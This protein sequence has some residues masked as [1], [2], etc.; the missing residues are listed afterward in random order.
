MP[1]KRLHILILM[2][3]L[4]FS[5]CMRLPKLPEQA[6]VPGLQV[7]DYGGMQVMHQYSD[8]GYVHVR[9]HFDWAD[10]QEYS[11]ATQLLAV[12]AAF[13]AG[14]GKYS[15]EV[16]AKKLENAGARMH[17]VA[18]KDGPVILVNVLPERIGSAFK[19]LSLGLA[20]PKF[21][22]EAFNDIRAARASAYNSNA[23][24]RKA[25]SLQLATSAT[26]S[27]LTK[28][29]LDLGKQTGNVSRV[30]ARQV[31]EQV[32]RQRC[33]LRWV[34]AGPVDVERI[35]DLLL[36]ITDVLA[37]GTCDEIM[38]SAME[39]EWQ[40]IQLQHETR[41]LGVATALLPAPA[42]TDN[43]AWPIR[44]LAEIMR[45]RLHQ[46]LVEKDRVARQVDCYYQAFEPACLVVQVSG[47]NAFQSA[48]FALSVLRNAREF[49]FSDAEVEAG[50][51]V[52]E[53][54]LGLG[55]EAAPTLAKRL[56]RAA[57]LEKPN[58]SGNEKILLQKVN[59]KYL[60]ALAKEYFQ[61]ISWG[62]VGD[63]TKV[64]RKSLL[65]L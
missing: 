47:K 14:A 65:R 46:K 20:A 26:W 58:L 44:M 35:S 42:A 34:I 11:K 64:D 62:L 60:Q 5:A 23:A 41:G 56:D 1:I 39:A 59:A 31:F 55:Y 38:P 54:Q 50:R 30:I 19:L 63:T 25:E 22:R 7:F 48:E 27:G 4:G 24:E 12:E 52:V 61:T 6:N 43:S 2:L 13:G 53:A 15:P 36:E 29:Q 40:N 49:G 18:E 51:N 10:W 21:E 9:L 17:F 33:R 28:S 16:Y 45:Q 8:R 32:M 3:S 37:E 57:V